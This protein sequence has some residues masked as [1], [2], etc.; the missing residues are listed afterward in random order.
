M[1]QPSCAPLAAEQLERRAAL[2]LIPPF[3]EALESAHIRL[4]PVNPARHGERLYAAANGSGAN[5]EPGAYDPDQMIWRYMFGGPY[6]DLTSFRAYVDGLAAMTNG[7]A[8]CV[9]DRTSGAP[10]GIATY[11]ANLPEM[12]RIELGGIWYT[13]RFQRSF[14]NT[15]TIYLMLR[16]AFEELGYR[17]LEWKCDA[18]NARSRAAALRLGFR[19][20]GVF[21]QHMI[22]KG[23][24][25]D[26]AWFAMLD[27]EWP[28]VR[29]QLERV[30]AVLAPGTLG[31][32]CCRS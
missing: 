11:C 12:L 31:S 18:A 28:E 1:T 14:A 13:P 20:E 17:R 8:L 23:R 30:I 24:N 10:I 9:I 2:P 27:S 26:T 5:G 15:E 25:R 4:E 7:L 32:D 6:P 29:Q 16:H 21:R 19:F 22:I 3:P